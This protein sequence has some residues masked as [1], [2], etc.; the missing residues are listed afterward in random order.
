MTPRRRTVLRAVWT[1]VAALGA[2][3]GC[4]AESAPRHPYAPGRCPDP[5]LIVEPNPD[6]GVAAWFV[7]DSIRVGHGDPEAGEGFDLDC[8]NTPPGHRYLPEDGPNGADNQFGWLLQALLEWGL[9]IDVDGDMQR[10]IEDARNLLVFRL[11]DVDDWANDGGLVYL[12]VYTGADSNTNLGDNLS[13]WGEL[14]VEARSLLDPTDVLSARTTFDMGV[15]FDNP[16]AESDIAVGDFIAAEADLEFEIAAGDARVPLP[17]HD[18]HVVWD[19]DRAPHGDPPLLGRVV[20]GLLGGNMLL[21]EAAQ[22]VPNTDPLGPEI[23]DNTLRAILA[24]QAD[25]DLIPAGFVD[26]SC[27]PSTV[28]DDCAPGQTCE[29]DEAR[30]DVRSCYEQPDNPDAISVAFVF[31][32]VS[33]DVVGIH[34]DT[35]VP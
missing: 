5:P 34:P 18:A 31:T 8:V 24:G 22:F 1:V 3:A 7:V 12:S 30:G 16:A 15:L 2:L 10:S 23:D 32:A 28:Q 33:C 29:Q 35:P 14:L 11:A 26:T 13:G 25:L 21:R 20:H 19:L 27:T 9:D 6:D 4:D 17:I